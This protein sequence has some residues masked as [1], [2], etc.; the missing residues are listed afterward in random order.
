MF[1]DIPNWDAYNSRENSKCYSF[2]YLI[3]F[4]GFVSNSEIVLN[5]AVGFYVVPA[6][7]SM[8]SSCKVTLHCNY[9]S[10]G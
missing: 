1:C 7:L 4:S 9:I 3:Q 10:E 2:V 8:I 5:R 6:M